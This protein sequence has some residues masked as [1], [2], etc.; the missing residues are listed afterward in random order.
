MYDPKAA[1]KVSADASSF[2]LGAVF[3][4]ESTDGWKPVAYASRSMNKTEQCYAQIEKEALA[5]TWACSKF[6][7]YILGR[8]FF[9]K[10]DHKP[11]V[12]LLNTKHL[13][14]LPLRVWLAKF[15]YSVFHIPGKLLYAADALSRAPM[16]Q[17]EEEPLDVETI[18]HF[19]LLA[20]I[21]Q[22]LDVYKQA[23]EM[24]QCVHKSKNTAQ[25]SGQLKSSSVPKSHHIGKSE[26]VSLYATF[27]CTII[28]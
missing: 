2:R 22:T 14:A 18:T 25:S 6:S 23:Q 28:V 16:P 15:N 21:K 19:T 26:T 11:L 4:Q 13:D 24:I 10:T 8:E 20:I 27:S 9:I 1:I 5:I 17:M 3:L 12:L 7:D